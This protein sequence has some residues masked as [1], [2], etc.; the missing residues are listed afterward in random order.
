MTWCHGWQVMSSH[1][2]KNPHTLFTTDATSFDVNGCTNAACA[3]I[4][5]DVKN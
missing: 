5:M 2:E 3:W 4:Y 1:Q